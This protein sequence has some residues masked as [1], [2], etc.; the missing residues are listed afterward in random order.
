M[1]CRTCGTAATSL[2]R[3]CPGCGERLLDLEAIEGQLRARPTQ[4]A[5]DEGD[6]Y[7]AVMKGGEPRRVKEV[8]DEPRTLVVR[9]DD[10]READAP[11]ASLVRASAEEKEWFEVS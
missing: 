8:V 6:R 4:R 3:Y 11:W 10:D 7:L 2:M 1:K 9:L 5:S